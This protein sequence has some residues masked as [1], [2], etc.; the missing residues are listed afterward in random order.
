MELSKEADKGNGKAV[1][2]GDFCS[3]PKARAQSE[4]CFSAIDSQARVMTRRSPQFRRGRRHGAFHPIRRYQRNHLD[5]L[6]KPDIS[7]E[8]RMIVI[9]PT[10]LRM[11]FCV[12]GMWELLVVA[13]QDL[14]ER[15]TS[16]QNAFCGRP[17]WSV[18]LQSEQFIVDPTA[19]IFFQKAVIEAMHESSHFSLV[20]N[21]SSQ[22]CIVHQSRSALTHNV[23]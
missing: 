1:V 20:P 11:R 8:G 3:S 14:S 15:K 7:P 4:V 23:L 6:I 12:G 17:M 19:W 10:S 21:N 5:S 13:K 2:G 16:G 9:L 18:I 22:P